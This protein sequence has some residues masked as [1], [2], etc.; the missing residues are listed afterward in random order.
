MSLRILIDLQGAQNGS[1]H[2]GIGRYSLALA[3]GIVRN[4]GKHRIFIL[5]NG[6]FPDTIAEIQ[7]SFA[8]ILPEDQ[9]LV[10]KSPGPVAELTVEN[11]W[12]RRAAEVLREYVIST[13]LPDALLVTSMVEGGVD[14]TVTSFARLRSTV[15]TAAVIYDLIPL[16]DIDRYFKGEAE[17]RWYHGKIDALRRVDYL[18]AISQSTMND[19]IKLLC[20]DPMRIVNISSAAENCFSSTVASSSNWGSL[21]KRFG[22]NRRY[23]M[24]SSA[25]D[26]RKNFQGLIRAYTALPARI[27]SDYQLVLVCKLD[28]SG[29]EELT[30]LAVNV[31]LAPQ[32][33]VLTGFVSD[34]DLIALYSACHLFVFPS[35]TEGFGL[36]ALEAMSCGTPT[37]GSNTTSVP[38][39]IGR[40]DALFDPSSVKEMTALMFKALTNA[41]FYQSLKAHAKTQ[42]AKFS[43]DETA[44]RAIDGMEKLVRSLPSAP[45]LSEATKRRN[46][47]ESLAEV[48]REFAPDDLEILDLARSIDANASAVTRLQTSAAFG[49]D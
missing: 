39:V 2:R 36:P 16:M 9:F 41:E 18:F 49:A 38:E 27:R 8:T 5:L 11:A 45:V 37:I 30:A 31:G 12:R 46:L 47:M 20:V 43:W 6:L 40:E 44:L 25:F 4:A 42:A 48:S 34:N 26:H 21:A 28:F 19:A 23:L 13:L 35:F 29:R 3:K 10:F 17:N 14:D 1:R 22:I 7:S 33:I 32:D 15:P 24:H